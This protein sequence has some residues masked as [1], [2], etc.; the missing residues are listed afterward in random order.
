MSAVVDLNLTAAVSSQPIA[1]RAMQIRIYLE[2]F[3]ISVYGIVRIVPK[4]SLQPG[5]DAEQNSRVSLSA[6]QL[7][8]QPEAAR[9]GRLG[10]ISLYS[11]SVV[12]P[13]DSHVTRAELL[14]YC[15]IGRCS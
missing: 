8:S 7:P 4:V 9:E 12:A 15:C 3:Q 14:K 6:V 5:P 2:P 1:C 11:V 10:N 13:A